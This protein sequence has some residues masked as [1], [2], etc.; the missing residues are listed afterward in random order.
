MLTGP[1]WSRVYPPRGEAQRVGEAVVVEHRADDGS[2]H[3]AQ[4]RGQ[5]APETRTVVP[6]GRRPAGDGAT[7]GLIAVKKGF[8]SSV[9]GWH[10]CDVHPEAGSAE[11]ACGGC[12]SGRSRWAPGVRPGPPEGDD[13]Q[14]DKDVGEVLFAA[15]D[16]AVDAVEQ[17]RNFVPNAVSDVY[18]G[19]VQRI[20]VWLP[21]AARVVDG[22]QSM[23]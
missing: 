22:H 19:R 14:G 15:G 20:S 23:L 11:E 16:V 18:A 5:S 4:R 13:Q 7:C 8:G 9:G 17:G 2:G 1:I 21:V 3:R 12:E 6:I 10:G